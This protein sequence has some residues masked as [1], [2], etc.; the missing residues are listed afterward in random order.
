MT[1]ANIFIGMNNSFAGLIAR[2]QQIEG[3]FFLFALQY[4]I[5]PSHY[6]FEG[7]TTSW[8]INDTRQV[9]VTPGSSYYNVL[10]CPEIIEDGECV[11]STMDY[12]DAFFGGL[13]TAE[14]NGRNF[15]I[16]GL[17]WLAGVRL[18][19]Y[20]ALKLLTYSGK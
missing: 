19:T 20:L 11:V 12:L 3:G 15:F 1:I 13:Y 5:V 9:V 18:F 14:H 4:W 16:L 2:P 6:V 17:G 7:I 10:D 8:F